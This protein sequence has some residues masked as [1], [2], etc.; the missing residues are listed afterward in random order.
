MKI[1]PVGGGL[2]HADMHKN[3]HD[4]ANHCFFSTLQTCLKMVMFVTQEYI[5]TVS[6]FI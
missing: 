6:M 5:M 3:R 2:F 4:E 1:H